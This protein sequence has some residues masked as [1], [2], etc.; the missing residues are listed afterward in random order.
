MEFTKDG[1]I[2]IF[3]EDS[4]SV[5]TKQ[6]F[7]FRADRDV[8]IE[9]GRNINMKATGTKKNWSNS[10]HDKQLDNVSTEAIRLESVAETHIKVGGEGRIEVNKDFKMES[11]HGHIDLRATQVAQKIDDVMHPRKD[12]R[13]HATGD[14]DVLAGNSEN[15]GTSDGDDLTSNI[16]LQTVNEKDNNT[17]VEGEQTL[18][19][20][21]SPAT[22][23][24]NLKT[25]GRVNVDSV[26][27]TS[28]KSSA[29]LQV[30][31]AGTDI[32]GGDINLNSGTVSITTAGSSATADQATIEAL[33]THK[34]AETDIQFM[35]PFNRDSRS[36]HIK[37]KV[38]QLESIMKRVPVHD[39]WAMHEDKVRPYVNPDRTDREYL[40]PIK[41]ELAKN[42][43]STRV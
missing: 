22:G 6:D 24:F 25:S 14:I 42:D 34:Q 43:L 9:A 10:Y 8:N 39:Q 13:I 18:G 11:L 37:G 20:A 31:N 5:H 23:H 30:S 16:N 36:V 2:D 29:K 17:I 12:V 1:K 40:N 15:F 38:L 26:L 21:V 4:V 41:D 35:F 7:N 3:A 33:L 32:D 27:D 19:S 28:L